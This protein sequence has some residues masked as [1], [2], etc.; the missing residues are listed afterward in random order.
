MERS[1]FRHKLVDLVGGEVRGKEAVVAVEHQSHSLKNKKVLLKEETLPNNN[2]E[3][4]VTIDY[5]FCR[6]SERLDPN[7]KAQQT[8]QIM[9]RAAICNSKLYCTELR[10][11]HN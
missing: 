4:I 2:N 5:N 7:R 11:I 9:K 10:C 1:A 3:F 8:A 6:S